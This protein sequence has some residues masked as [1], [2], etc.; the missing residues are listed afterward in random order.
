MGPGAR[1]DRPLADIRQET[2]LAGHCGRSVAPAHSLHEESGVERGHASESFF[3]RGGHSPPAVES[4][5]RVRLLGVSFATLA[6]PGAS[7]PPRR[8]CAWGWAG[9]A[10]R[11]G[12]VA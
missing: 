12:A 11:T 9:S 6:M 2:G 3:G 5:A 4:A 7:Q 1:L 8:G 10:V